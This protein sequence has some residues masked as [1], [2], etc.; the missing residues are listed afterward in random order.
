MEALMEEDMERLRARRRAGQNPRR[1]MHAGG[2]VPSPSNSTFSV[3]SNNSSVILGLGT[4]LGIRDVLPLKSTFFDWCCEYFKEPQM[5]QAEVDEPGSAQ[6]NYQVWRQ[7]RNE[8]VVMD[9]QAQAPTAEH[10]KWDKPVATL[11]INGHPLTMAFHSYDRHLVVANEHDM[12]SVWDWSQRVRLNYFCNGNPPGTSV[13]SLCIINQD[14]GGIIVTGS[15]EGIVRLY[16]N[17]DPSMSQGP[18]QMV[19]AFRGLNEMVQMRQGS[20]MVTDWKQA[21]GTLLVGGDSRVIKAWDAQTETQGLVSANPQSVAYIA[22]CSTYRISKPAL[23]A[24]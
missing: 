6:Y 15:S 17:Y 22:Q 14:V 21:A 3:D 13:T 24:L 19:S 20:G 12:I 1:H 11:Q 9:T 2:G 10:C 8:Q 5:R 7:Q 4:G 16:R 23:I 18:I